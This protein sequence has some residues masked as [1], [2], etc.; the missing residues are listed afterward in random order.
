MAV[1]LYRRGDDA[2]RRGV[3]RGLDAII[4]PTAAW[5]DA[6]LELVAD[7]LRANDTRLVAA[8]LGAFA[9][10][11]LDDHAWRHG[12]LKCVFLGIPLSVVDALDARADDELA[13]MAERF[14]AERRA[15]G[16]SVPDDLSFLRARE[17]A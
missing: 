14:A 3:L 17:R 15:A 8:A 5:R 6:G 1:A 9:A 11:H 7:A 13:A 16:R 2:E 10:D 4:A 12:V